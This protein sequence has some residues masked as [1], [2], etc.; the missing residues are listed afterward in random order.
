MRLEWNGKAEAIKEAETPSTKMLVHDKKSSLN[1]Y[2]SENVFLEGDNIE[3]LK[4]LSD[5]RLLPQR[6]LPQL[7]DESGKIKIKMIYI[8]PPY[9]T[10]KRK[11]LY[12]DN[13]SGHDNWLNMIY[14]RLVLAQKL[15]RDD[16]VIYISI[17]DTEVASLRLVCDEIFG[18]KNFVSQLIWHR[19]ATRHNQSKW[20]S[21]NHEY[22]LMYAKCK[23]KF[24][25]GRLPRPDEMNKRYKNPDNDPRG[26]WEAQCMCS[27]GFFINQQYP[28]T[29]PDGVVSYPPS[30]V[31]WSHTKDNYEKMLADG[32]I[33]FSK[34][35]RPNKKAFL[36]EI[37]KLPHI[38]ELNKKYKNPD[39]DPR[40]LW[41]ADTMTAI[42]FRANQQYPITSPDGVVSYP[43]E[44]RSWRY[45]KETYNKMLADGRIVFNSKGKPCKKSFLNELRDSGMVPSSML[46][47]KGN[48]NLATKEIQD[49]FDIDI[50]FG[51][52]GT[53]RKNTYGSA[54]TIEL[55]KLFEGK[56]PF[57]NP[58]PQRL[59]ELLLTMANTKPKDII[60]DFFAGSSSTAE[61]VMR[62]N[63]K[64][65]YERR[66]IMVTLP[67]E[68]DE[69]SP[70]Y[71]AGY[72]NIAELST[73]R[74]KR[75]AYQICND[76]NRN[77][78]LKLDLG[79]N[80]YTIDDV[81]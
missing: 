2:V 61:A 80:A 38:D 37:G 53:P 12:K 23:D 30:G 7:N 73:E 81:V 11:R 57:D 45:I 3:A 60:M 40:G 8:D 43:P 79:F 9:N 15:L 50:H 54:G 41:K 56:R 25:I 35:G 1:M 34:T 36:N 17:D 20:V 58:K 46:F 48:E 68:C 66:F 18:E 14:P 27:P 21:T 49:L 26:A 75:A 71:K 67:V 10:G 47:Y 69:N 59:L 19:S 31:S 28:I 72:K 32:R 63:S 52:K 16:G 44:G 24:E 74:I 39:N 29:S 22:I 55:Q 76:E 13:Y 33:V 51:E 62:M 6:L 78:E 5:T 65:G 64:D 77:R 4:L 42:G 70:A